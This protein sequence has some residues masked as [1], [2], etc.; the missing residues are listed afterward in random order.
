MAYQKYERYK[1]NGYMIFIVLYIKTI[2]K[3]SCIDQ[4]YN[5]YSLL[6][7]METIDI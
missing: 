4:Q 2:L 6:V 7:V 1:E 5:V 3:L